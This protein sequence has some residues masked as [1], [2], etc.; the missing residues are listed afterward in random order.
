MDAADGALKCPGCAATVD[1]WGDH[2]M[3]C[4]RSNFTHRHTALQEVV[5]TLLC[6]AGQSF[7]KEVAIPHCPDGQLRPA[8]L[9]IPGWDNGNDMALDVTLVHGWQLSAQSPASS[10]SRERWRNF[11]RKK[12]QLK[13]QK[14][15]AACK[16]AGWSFA[17]LAWGRGGV[18]AQKGPAPCR[19]S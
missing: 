10:I 18:W 2:L 13:H 9:L 4:N 14:Y 16:R 19:G 7:T 11:L 5:A 15:D 6:E 8:D 1:V 12:E 17:P 3:C